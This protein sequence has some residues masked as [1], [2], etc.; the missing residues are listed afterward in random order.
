MPKFRFTGQYTG[1]RDSI[2][3]GGVLFVGNEPSEVAD[4]EAVRRLRGHPE[5]EEVGDNAGGLEDI[6]QLRAEYRSLAGKNGGPK[7]DEATYREKIAA[8]KAAQG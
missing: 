2:D 1:G 7:W 4:P 6:N 8:L 5:F 3:A